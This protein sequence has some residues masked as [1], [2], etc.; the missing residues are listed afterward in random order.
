MGTALRIA[1]VS[2]LLVLP[3]CASVV[4]GHS[5][6]LTFETNPAGAECTLTRNGDVL[7]KVTTPG[8]FLVD[9]TKYGINVVCTKDGYEEAKGFVKSD[10]EGMTFGNLVIGGLIG[11]GIDSATGADNKYQEVNVVTLTPKRSAQPLSSTPATTAGSGAERYDT[12]IPRANATPQAQ[13]QQVA[14]AAPKPPLPTIVPFNPPRIGTRIYPDSGGYYEITAV[15]GA[16]VNTVNAA[17]R[18]T[19]WVGL[20]LVPGDADSKQFD[21][22][23]A[24]SIWPLEVGKSVTLNMS[25]IARSGSDSAWQE[26][27]T[28]VRQEEITTEAGRFQT[29][30]VETRERSL[31]GSFQSRTTRWY[32]PEVGFVVKY[33][34]EI[35][36]GSGRPRSWTVARIVPPTY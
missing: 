23:V 13:P 1:A 22:A 14:S 7:G 9:K 11:W 2:L 17:A 15:T 20:F 33:R 30:V 35:E 16:T 27:I 21:V 26:T 8:Q 34:R 32:A 6:K 31:A 28:V 36:R 18:E 24:E 5:Q 3:A 29:V 4:E 19:R 25:G 12:D 10:V